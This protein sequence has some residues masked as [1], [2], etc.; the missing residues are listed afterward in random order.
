MH[1]LC[2]KADIQPQGGYSRQVHCSSCCYYYIH[3][4]CFLN[5][6]TH[7]IWAFIAPVILII[8]INFVLFLVVARVMWKH[9]KRRTDKS[10]ASN[11]K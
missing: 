8:A 10:K 7:F 2:G 9:Q 3:F 11:V 4:S 1:R 6:E 5:A